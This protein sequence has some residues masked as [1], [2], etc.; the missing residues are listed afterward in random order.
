MADDYH[1]RTETFS[2]LTRYFSTNFEITN[3]SP[4]GQDVTMSDALKES[5]K[6]FGTCRAFYF[7]TD[8]QFAINQMIK[9]DQLSKNRYDSMR[10]ANLSIHARYRKDTPALNNR[11]IHED[12]TINTRAGARF[13]IPGNQ[14]IIPDQD[15]EVYYTGGWHPKSKSLGDQIIF[16]EQ[17]LSFADFC[18]MKNP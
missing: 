11:E 13:I 5:V 16:D 8:L 2:G 7:Y 1:Y 10:I 4:T 17:N 18:K 9:K 15:I 6:K 3:R 14:V 12:G